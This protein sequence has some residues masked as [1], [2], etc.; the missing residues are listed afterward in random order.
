MLCA[1]T[2]E[3][4]VGTTE[5]VFR[6][7]AQG[8]DHLTTA[9]GLADNSVLTIAEAR[10]GAVLVGTNDGFSRVRG[11][12]IE[13]FRA[14]DGLSQSSVY[15][16]HEDREG[17]LWVATGH[18]LNQFLDG[19]ST[20]YT[21]SE[22]LP[23]N[24]TGPVVRD[25]AGVIWTG[26][27]GAGLARFDGH[28]FSTFTTHDG[29]ASNDV[30]ALVEDGAGALWVGTD[31]GLTLVR[32]GLVRRRPPAF[33]PTACR[34]SWSMAGTLAG[35]SR[36][37]AWRGDGFVPLPAAMARSRARRRPD[38]ALYIG[39]NDAG[40]QIY[41]DGQLRDVADDQPALRHVDAIYTDSQGI[42]WVGTSGEGLLAI[43]HGQV[44]KFT[45]RDGLFDDAIY[46]I[47]GD[48]YGRLWM[49]CSR[50]IFSVERA[51]ILRFRSEA[52]PKLTST[53]YSPTDALRTI[54]CQPACSRRAAAAGSCG[55]DQPRCSCSTP[56][57]TDRRFRCRGVIRGRHGER[58]AR[59]IWRTSPRAAAFNN[60]AFR[61]AELASSGP[62][63]VPHGSR[64]STRD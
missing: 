27:L 58:R 2:G 14:E 59:P 44:S 52:T 60:V 49:A 7:S 3:V 38:G 55:F 15:A 47:L 34:H 39:S 10:D 42:V 19:R 12:D 21:T 24:H 61:Y 29:L 20:P 4:W 37:G 17:T 46:A 63:H 57:T 8:D 40:L 9:N 18:G 28:T 48:G 51:Q 1:R 11:R 36:R 54:E 50:G 56:G 13:S 32:G 53:P 16:L 45:V 35:T 43:D 41:A 5:G 22:G 25:H 31:R 23:S 64:V 30:L 6:L 26:T 62:D 33:P